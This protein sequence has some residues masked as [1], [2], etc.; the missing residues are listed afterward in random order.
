MT[1]GKL[2]AA[3]K[4]PGGCGERAGLGPGAAAAGGPPGP[5]AE[6]AGVWPLPRATHTHYLPRSPGL[7]GLGRARLGTLT[8]GRG[9]R[10]EGARRAQGRGLCLGP[11][12]PQRGLG[13]LSLARRFGN[14][15]A[16]PGRSL[17]GSGPHI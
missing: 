9:P 8:A 1:P 10:G 4:A 7:L 12:R 15:A 3:R 14:R 16:S 17:G 5:N 6:S 11:V 2:R 13:A